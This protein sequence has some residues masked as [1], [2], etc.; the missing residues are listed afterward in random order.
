M[1]YTPINWQNNATTPLNAANLNTMDSQ[2]EKNATVSGQTIRLIVD[3]VSGSDTTGGYNNPTLP[4]KTLEYVLTNL[5]INATATVYMKGDVAINS[6]YTIVTN[7]AKVSFV[8]W[9]ETDGVAAT[10]TLTLGASCN[11]IANNASQFIFAISTIFNGVENVKVGNASKLSLEARLTASFDS[12]GD[13]TERDISDSVITI[14]AENAITL[15]GA[16][17]SVRTTATDLVFSGTTA[18][19]IND[20]AAIVLAMAATTKVNG[21]LMTPTTA[22][23]LFSGMKLNTAGTVVHNV[24][25]NYDLPLVGLSAV[26]NFEADNESF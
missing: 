26:T 22:T 19:A 8:S 23:G 21:T 13:A 6:T 14:N 24:L 20:N 15:F 7:A 1:A 4:F 11:I 18:I 2:I 25:A 10:N 3:P 12:N 9:G 5:P 17:T 16:G